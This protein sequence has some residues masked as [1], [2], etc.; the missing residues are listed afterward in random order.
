MALKPVISRAASTGISRLR[1]APNRVPTDR[2]LPAMCAPSPANKSTNVEN[3]YAAPIDNT[4]VATWSPAT[5]P[6]QLTGITTKTFALWNITSADGAAP[7]ILPGDFLAFL[8]QDNVNSST[9][10]ALTSLGLLV[11]GVYV[12]A[13]AIEM[14]LYNST[15]GTLATPVGYIPILLWERFNNL[16]TD[17]NAMY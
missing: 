15:G 9:Y 8:S 2:S 5:A 6:T 3:T 13:G 12:Q 10:D 11:V 1:I 17:P 16:S 7:D 14:L 4:M